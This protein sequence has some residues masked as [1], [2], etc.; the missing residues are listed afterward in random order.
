MADQARGLL[1]PFLRDRRLAAARPYLAEGRVLDYGCGVG[2]LAEWIEPSRYLGVDV[3]AASLEAAKREHPEHAFRQLDELGAQDLEAGFETIVALAVIEH[4]PDPGSWLDE[5]KR[6][7][8]PSGRLVLTTPEPQLRRF[9]ELGARLGLFSREAAE[10]HNVMVSRS[11][12]V[13]LAAAADLELV[14]A[15]RFLLGCNQLFVLRS[16]R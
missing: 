12:M 4:V 3:D 6:W 9:H 1:S 10:E 14:E 15:A 16:L 2:V 11:M 5:V 8:S 7:L 13:D